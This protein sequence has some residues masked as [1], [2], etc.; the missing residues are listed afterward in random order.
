MPELI[1]VA[2]IH[3]L[4]LASPGPDFLVVVKHAASGHK[5]LGLI[6][7]LGVALGMPIHVAYSLLGVGYVIAQ[8]VVLFSF[9]KLLGA[10]YLFYL[11][12]K[13]IHH[14]TA[15]TE[16][17]ETKIQAEG[18]LGA[19]F[20]AGFLTNA[21]NPKATLFF[22]ALFTQVIHPTTPKSVQLLYGLEMTLVTCI[23]FSLIALLLSHQSVQKG[24]SAIKRHTDRV[25][26]ALLIALGLK[27]AF[28]SH[29]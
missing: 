27:V 22:L 2:V 28:S 20:R 23:W 25:F 24:F 26:G 8:S 4:A 15:R 21:L 7:A 9:I 16:V 10:G 13:T 1:T 11:G 5:K 14:S 29:K 18:S 17:S 3:L 19:A 12:I 6:T